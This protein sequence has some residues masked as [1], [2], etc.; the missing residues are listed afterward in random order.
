MVEGWNML[1]RFSEFRYKEVISVKTGTRLGYVCDAEFQA[2]EGRISALVVPG[3]AKYFGL[4]GR[5]EDYILPWE[6]ITRV[7]ED[8]ILVESEASIRRGKRPKHPFFS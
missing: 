5:E 6:C 3:K 1:C 7:G 2:A 8:I 4:L